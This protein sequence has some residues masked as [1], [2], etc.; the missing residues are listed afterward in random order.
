MR[1]SYVIV[2]SVVPLAMLMM[3]GVQPAAGVGPEIDANVRAEYPAI[4]EAWAAGR[5]EQ[6]LAR[7]DALESGLIRAKKAERDIKELWVAKL[8]VI[9]ETMAR[10]SADVLVPIMLLHHDAYRHYLGKRS[11]WLSKHSH[12]MSAELAEVYAD[13]STSPLAARTAADL[14][15]SL[16][17]HMQ[18][19]L[20]LN[21][22]AELFD[23]ALELDYSNLAAHLGL[24]ALYERRTEVELAD[25]HFETAARLHPG[26]AEAHL[27]HG[28]CAARRGDQ[29][30]ARRA[31]DSVLALS[32]PAWVVQIAFQEIARLEEDGT[33]VARRGR[34]RFPESSR[35]AIQLAFM[36]EQ[37]RQPARALE[38]VNGLSEQPELESERYRYARWPSAA[39]DEAR[40]RLRATAA[41]LDEPLQRAVLPVAT[42]EASQ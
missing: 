36:L 32:E 22:S 35:Q 19:G 24:G 2:R 17:G 26:S 10:S 12:E 30:A 3:A 42:S 5:E 40:Q 38:I 9:R 15:A 1:E 6:A 23:R 37:A 27:R 11:S 8:G 28:L 4:L 29:D 7:L 16:G 21:R 39:L 34:S 14:L 31:L 13:R 20:V 25:K 18:A 33:E 41:A